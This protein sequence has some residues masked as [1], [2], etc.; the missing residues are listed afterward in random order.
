MK[1]YT[2]GGDKGLTSLLSGQR[3]PKSHLRVEAYGTVD[4]LNA[5]IGHLKDQLNVAGFDENIVTYLHAVNRALFDTGSLLALDAE[6]YRGKKAEFDEAAV[7]EM[8]GLIDELEEKL[9]PLREF[10]LPAGH[11][12]I[13]YSHIC[14]TVCRRAERSVV[15]LAGEETVDERYITYLNRLSDFLFVLARYI[16]AELDVEEEKWH[17]E[18]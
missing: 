6:N 3:I 13:S 8:E 10:I 2:K 7:R 4:E 9:T 12:L 15:R 18:S 17:S 1:I 14:R 11:V 5:H 16:A